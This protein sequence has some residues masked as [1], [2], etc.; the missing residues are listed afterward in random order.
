M[1]D[2]SHAEGTCLGIHPDREGEP[3]LV[4]ALG[5]SGTHGWY[6]LDHIS[7]VQI[8]APSSVSHLADRTLALLDE[9]GEIPLDGEVELTAA[10]GE[11]VRLS[12]TI[13]RS[14]V[15]CAPDHGP[16]PTTPNPAGGEQGR[17]S[18]FK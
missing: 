2:G 11:H 10:A 3:N 15:R 13:R 4:L 16:A 18:I 17:A 12:V 5:P 1:S 9:P 6:P 14:L 8:A 7:E